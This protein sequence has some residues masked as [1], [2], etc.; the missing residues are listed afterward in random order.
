MALLSDGA[1]GGT[2]AI[3]MVI[4]SDSFETMDDSSAS[5]ST[6]EPFFRDGHW[7]NPP[8]ARNS[9]ECRVSI[10]AMFLAQ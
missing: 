1:L 6:M 7:I 9:L 8:L 2:R 4:L 5:F 3:G 10:Q